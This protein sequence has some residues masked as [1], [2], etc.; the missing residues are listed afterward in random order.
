MSRLAFLMTAYIYLDILF[1]AKSQLS[2]DLRTAACLFSLASKNEHWPEDVG[3]AFL[4]NRIPQNPCPFVKIVQDWCY[5]C[6]LWPPKIRLLPADVVPVFLADCIYTLNICSLAK[7][8]H[9]CFLNLFIKMSDRRGTC[10]FSLA[11]KMDIN[12]AYV[13]SV[14]LNDCILQNLC[15]FVKSKNNVSHVCS[16]WHPKSTRRIPMLGLL[17]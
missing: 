15:P 7:L 8:P 1:P 4:T 3:P 10:L 16:L 14:F 9:F 5:V 12:E 2:K 17:S 13:R 6:S 11:S